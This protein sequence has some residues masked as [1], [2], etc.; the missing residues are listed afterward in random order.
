VTNRTRL[1][2]L[3]VVAVVG[4]VSLLGRSQNWL[5]AQQR[6]YRARLEAA[7]THGEWV[8]YVGDGG[9]TVRAYL[10]YPERPDVAPAMI[11]IHEIFGL[12]DWIRTVVDDFAARGYV[13]IAPDLLT[14]RGG[15]TG[16]DA[17]RRIIADLPRDSLTVDLDATLA[18]VGS[19][20]A[21][22]PEA[23]GVIG[24]CWGGR[25]AF[26]Y[27]TNNQTI[28]A[29]VV[30][31]GSAPSPESMGRIAAPILGVYA[32]NDA[33][34]NREIPAVEQAMAEAAKDYRYR[35]Y[36]GTGHGFLRRGTPADEVERA[37]EDIYRFL[38]AQLAR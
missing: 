36:P 11:V 22:D 20:K 26:D 25:R 33:R 34:I 32:E 9:D 16:A 4:S 1:V 10:A 19:L 29:A 35:I 2:I 7:T 23:V 14:R 24:F 21:V 5:A 37:W 13:T 28:Q 12:S 3:G 38:D 18:Y 30:C 31:Y 17:A 6:D 15:T 27:A 8:K